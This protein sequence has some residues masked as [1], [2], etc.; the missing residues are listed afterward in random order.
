MDVRYIVALGLA[1]IGASRHACEAAPS[2]SRAQTPAPHYLSEALLARF[3][4]GTLQVP[5]GEEFSELNYRL[6]IPEIDRS[7]R[8]PL[9]LCLAGH[10]RRQLEDH[11]VGQLSSIDR[12]IL[13]DAS[14]LDT[15]PFFILAPQCP[16][17]PDGEWLPWKS[18]DSTGVDPIEAVEALVR[19]VIEQYPVDPNRIT[20]FGISSGGTASWEYARRY[21][22]RF[23]AIVPLASFPSPT[24]ELA[25]LKDVSVWAFHSTGD[26]PET[27]RKR[28]SELQTLGGNSH[29][30]EIPVN[31]HAC[32]HQAFGEYELLKWMLAQNRGSGVSRDE[33]TMDAS[34]KWLVFKHDYLARQ[35]WL[36]LWSFSWPRIVPLVALI[37]LYIACRRHLRGRRASELNRNTNADP[38]IA[39]Q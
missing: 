36:R 9:I 29:L 32:W 34:I 38:A 13:P 33:E 2:E 20:V 21:P 25:K 24:K 4:P 23:A 19:N 15:Y 8:Y 5:N 12:M 35:A 7:K 10:G 28:V 18:S 30:T 11:N 37:S 22:E 6:F 17:S 26:K 39:S 16:K 14:A 27:V 1:L 31:A 3:Q